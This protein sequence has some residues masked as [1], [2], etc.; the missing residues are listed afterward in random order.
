[1]SAWN[2]LSVDTLS[3]P[4]FTETGKKFK[5]A[6]HLI[7]LK[8]GCW[9]KLDTSESW[10]HCCPAMTSL[11]LGLFFFHLCPSWSLC[12]VVTPSS[13]M[14][15]NSIDASRFVQLEDLKCNFQ[16]LNLTFQVL[17][18]AH[19]RIIAYRMFGNAVHYSQFSF[20]L[21][22]FPSLTDVV[23][24]KQGA[25]QA[26]WIYCGYQN[27]QQAGWQWSRHVPH[28]WNTGGCLQYII[29]ARPKLLFIALFSSTQPYF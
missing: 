14:Y 7:R 17:L 28:H 26:S 8:G 22:Y 9:E 1:M 18:L 15:G 16:P 11:Q 12:S 10:K 21:S 3:Y 2:V 20:P 27:T 6:Q 23:G 19:I 5:T 25:Q 4:R 24:Y 13:F 29:F